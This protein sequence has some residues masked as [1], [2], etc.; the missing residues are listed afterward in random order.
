[1][2]L[3]TM[4]PVEVLDGEGGSFFARSPD[5]STIIGLR[6][7]F[8]L[9]PF[10]LALHHYS[11]SSKVGIVL[12]GTCGVVGMLL[13]DQSSE[14]R[15]MKLTKGD[16][17]PVPLA[18]RRHLERLYSQNN[19]QLLP[20]WLPSHPGWFLPYNTDTK[21]VTELTKSQPHQ[22]IVK[23]YPHNGIGDLA[24][25]KAIVGRPILK[26]RT[27]TVELSVQWV[28]LDAGA[29]LG[30]TYTADTSAKVMYM[31]GGSGKVDIVGSI[32]HL[33]DQRTQFN[34]PACCRK[35][36]GPGTSWVKS[37]YPSLNK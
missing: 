23:L 5:E 22:L 14:E 25:T 36:I 10:G 11:D 4:P 34:R 33:L 13:P 16:M 19:H 30:P 35:F 17:I 18:T 32:G 28:R 9:H 3:L 15:V 26:D 12:Q 20:G 21:E 29:S 37:Q 31:V 7:N 2:E 24:T 6:R 8:V 1:M 27:S